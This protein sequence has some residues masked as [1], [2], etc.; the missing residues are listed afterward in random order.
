MSHHIGGGRGGGS[1]YVT[2]RRIRSSDLP[3]PGPLELQII[4]KRAADFKWENGRDSSENE[5]PLTEVKAR[6]MRR[7]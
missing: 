3:L 4:I 5:T 2:E 1:T 6:D 7:E